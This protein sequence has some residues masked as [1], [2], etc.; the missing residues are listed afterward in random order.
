MLFRLVHRIIMSK[1]QGRKQAQTPCTQA[2]YQGITN[3]DRSAS[4]VLRA[5]VPDPNLSI[6]DE[7]VCRDPWLQLGLDAERLRLDSTPP[8]RDASSLRDDLGDLGQ[9]GS[10]SPVYKEVKGY[11]HWWAYATYHPQ[12]RQQLSNPRVTAILPSSATVASLNLQSCV[13]KKQEGTTHKLD[14]YLPPKT[15]N[16]WIDNVGGRAY[17]QRQNL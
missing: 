12:L 4:V 5:A 1:R 10:W 7:V 6:L 14:Q 15:R 9:L 13:W 2:H 11:L 3:T 8:Q 17:G 16:K